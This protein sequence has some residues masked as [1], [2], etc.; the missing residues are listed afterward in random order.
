M[1]IFGYF[2]SKN[3]FEIELENLKEIKFFENVSKCRR[4]LFHFE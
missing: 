1:S 3:Q 2:C 4:N